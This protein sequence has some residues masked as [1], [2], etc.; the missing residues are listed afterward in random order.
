MKVLQK[1]LRVLN[2]GKT[3]ECQKTKFFILGKSIIGG[4]LVKQD[5]ADL[6]LKCFTLPMFRLA[7]KIV[8]L[9]VTVAIM[10][11]LAT[12]YLCNMSLKMQARSHNSYLKKM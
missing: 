7:Q 1:T 12:M 9:L 4:V 5:L 11:K 6:I 2:F 8:V 3:L 10:L